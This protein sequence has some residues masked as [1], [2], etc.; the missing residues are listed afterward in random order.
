MVKE[1]EIW[2][3]ATTGV[4]AEVVDVLGDQVQIYIE[5]T[6]HQRARDA[7]LRKEAF[8]KWYDFVESNH[9]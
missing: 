8:L 5:R 1:G 9:L 2:Q 3:H 7:I 4:K 6:E